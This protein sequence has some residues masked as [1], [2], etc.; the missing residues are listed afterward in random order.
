MED[1]PKGP[2]CGVISSIGLFVV[3]LLVLLWI[4]VGL[5]GLNMGGTLVA[6][7]LIAAIGVHIY[8][9]YRLESKRR[10]MGG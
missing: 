10:T 3:V 9:T 6:T 1:A 7:I 2:Y 4:G 8:C 5:L